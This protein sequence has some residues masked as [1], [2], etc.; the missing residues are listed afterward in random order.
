[1]K[2]T[3]CTN[4]QAVNLINRAFNEDGFLINPNSRKN[5]SDAKQILENATDIAY[6]LVNGCETWDCLLI[7]AYPNRDI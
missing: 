6:T 5:I 7:I 3:T 4:Q 2:K 1:M